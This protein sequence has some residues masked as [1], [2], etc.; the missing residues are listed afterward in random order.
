MLG[1]GRLPRL[2]FTGLTYHIINRGNNRREVLV[3]DE[4]FVKYIEILK[5]YKKQY[6]FRLY[7]Y[8]LMNNHV[9]LLLEATEDGTV[10]RIMQGITLSHTWHYKKK[11]GGCGHVWQGRFKRPVIE[12]ESYLLECA[13][14]I[15][16]NP[17]R[18]KMVEDPLEY[19]WSSYRSY[20]PGETNP[21]HGVYLGWRSRRHGLGNKAVEQG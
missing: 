14:Y 7:H 5:R 9:H 1:M 20:A 12:K 13:R 16:L 10:S 2:T 17:V 4:D 21:L 8:V 15:E 19:R 6:G 18:A 11:Y 3:D